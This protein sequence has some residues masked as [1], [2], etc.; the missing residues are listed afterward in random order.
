MR[1]KYKYEHLHCGFCVDVTDAGCSHALCPHILE[2][3]DDLRH[4]PVFREA[5][6][7]AED[8]PTFHR[9]TLLLLQKSSETTLT[10]KTPTHPPKPDCRAHPGFKPAC[11][12]CP[13]PSVGFICYDKRD[14]SCL[15]DDVDRLTRGRKTH[16]PL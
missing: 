4:D 1:F 7:L 13:F 16:A 10:K 3:L 11:E 6:A 12:G 8:C 2:N 9:P 5:V 15:K 14:G